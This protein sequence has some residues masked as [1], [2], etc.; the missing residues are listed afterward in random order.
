MIL[1]KNI[2]KIM[3]RFF[4]SN[5]PLL[6]Y[7]TKQKKIN[8]IS[9]LEGEELIGEEKRMRRRKC[10]LSGTKWKLW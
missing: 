6:S 3:K 8:P 7:V 10:L 9:L 4:K 5:K 2:N 1:D